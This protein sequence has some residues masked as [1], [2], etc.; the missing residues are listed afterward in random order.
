MMAQADLKT[1]SVAIRRVRFTAAWLVAGR[2]FALKLGAMALAGVVASANVEEVTVAPHNSQLEMSP[3]AS[4]Q[5]ETVIYRQE[6]P[7]N[8]AKCESRLFRPA[9]YGAD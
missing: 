8:P 5:N 6:R 4:V 9:V 1:L 3:L 2:P 7:T